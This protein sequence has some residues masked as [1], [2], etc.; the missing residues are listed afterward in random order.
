MQKT[1][2]V[3]LDDWKD[4]GSWIGTTDTDVKVDFLEKGENPKFSLG[5][6]GIYSA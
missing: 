5:H 2:I 3:S 6:L 1:V 4:D